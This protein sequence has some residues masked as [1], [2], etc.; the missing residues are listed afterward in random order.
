MY[1][2]LIFMLWFSVSL[3]FF[4]SFASDIN[5][6]TCSNPQWCKPI[7]NPALKEIFA[8]WT[9]GDDWK[10]QA[11]DWD[12][13]TTICA[14]ADIPQEL[15]CHAHAHNARVVFGTNFP[16]DQLTNASA[17]TAW[18]KSTVEKVKA[19]YADG[20]NVDIE[21]NSANRDDLTTLITELYSELKNAYGGYQLSFD[22]AI[23]PKGQTKG[24][25][26]LALSKHLDF[27]VPMA[28]DECWGSLHATA[29]SPFSALQ[30]GVQEYASLGVDVDK[31]VLGLPWYAWKWPCS[32]ATIGQTCNVVV[33]AGKK[34]YGWVTQIS[35]T[36]AH[37][38]MVEKAGGNATLDNA[39]MTKYFDFLIHLDEMHPDENERGNGDRQQIWFDDPT[40]LGAKYSEC[41]KLG[42]RGV[43]FWTADEVDYTEGNLTADM[44]AAL[45]QFNNPSNFSSVYV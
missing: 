44:W 31:L 43:A 19:N 42:I 15:I 38:T 28:Y 25:D 6:C 10:Q 16:K 41:K 2:R 22:L 7:A 12:M 26:H 4:S 40:T 8:F 21:G 1:R 9:G 24:Y 14:F 5:A 27:I 36:T 45:R 39:T 29:N 34:W 20:V 18:V 17:R 33:P 32:V 3:D 35:Y 30:K 11:W 23:F 13:T 37:N